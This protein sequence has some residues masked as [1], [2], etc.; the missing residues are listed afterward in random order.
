MQSL[1]SRAVST[2]L[3]TAIPAALERIDQF[4]IGKVLTYQKKPC[5][6]L[7]WRRRELNFTGRSINDLLADGQLQELSFATSRDFLFDAGKGTDK[8]S[9]EVSMQSCLRD[10]SLDNNSIFAFYNIVCFSTYVGF[11]SL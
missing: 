1:F 6:L 4:A 7:P 11:F 10:C 5:K 8:I 3:P 9:V 2:N